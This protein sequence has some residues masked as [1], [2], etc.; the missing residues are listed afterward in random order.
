[1]LANTAG[2][3]WRSRIRA[4]LSGSDMETS[5]MSEHVTMS[6]VKPP[7]AS[8]PA[9]SSRRTR[10]VPIAATRKVK[11]LSSPADTHF[12]VYMNAKDPSPSQE[13]HSRGALAPVFAEPNKYDATTHLVGQSTFTLTDDRGTGEASCLPGASRDGRRREA[14]L[15]DCVAS[16]P[17]HLR[18]ARRR[19][20]FRRAPAPCRLDRRTRTLM[21]TRK[22][23]I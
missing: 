17:Q 6:R 18:E 21:T 5:F 9:S 15:D 16:L 12:V 1:M 11:C 13:L 14:A 23:T 3:M 19:M 22:R 10:I 8:R 7:I 4:A 20:A 2:H